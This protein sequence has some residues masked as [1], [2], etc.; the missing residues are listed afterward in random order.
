M[1][2]NAGRMTELIHCIKKVCNGFCNF[3]LKQL[4]KFF[5]LNDLNHHFI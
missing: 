2:E 4:I 1:T 3:F 5:S